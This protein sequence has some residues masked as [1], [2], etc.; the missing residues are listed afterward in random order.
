M[1]A[2]GGS[3]D[4]DERQFKPPVSIWRVDLPRFDGRL[5]RDS[6][7]LAAGLPVGPTALP[8][9]VVVFRHFFATRQTRVL[10][11]VRHHLKPSLRLSPQLAGN[12]L[13]MGLLRLGHLHLDA[14][15]RSGM[16]PVHAD[17]V[18]VHELRRQTFSRQQHGQ[19][20]RINHVIKHIDDNKIGLHGMDPGGF[21][22]E[23][24]NVFTL[25][26]RLADRRA[27]NPL[28]VGAPIVCVG[29]FTSFVGKPFRSLWPLLRLA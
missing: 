12:L 10:V 26:M 29:I 23:T 16:H 22:L 13:G 5:I 27:R 25:E 28:L 2:R 6:V 9:L 1:G 11:R 14:P 20:L 19:H 8:A 17:G 3:L 7:G 15:I 24:R 21:A 18:V 4:G